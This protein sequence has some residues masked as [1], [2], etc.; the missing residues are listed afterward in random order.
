MKEKNIANNIINSTI[1][2]KNSYFELK[3]KEQGI[4]LVALVITII[5]L[6]ILAT[7]AINFAFGNNGLIQRAE[8]ARDYY[9]NDTSYTDESITNVE[10]YLN[11]IIGGNGGSSSGGKTLVQAFNDGEIKVGDY[12]DYKNPTSGTY[13][14]YATDT[15]MDNAGIDGVTDQVFDVSKNQLN[16]R[17]LGIDEET[18]GLKL[19][20]GSPMKSDNIVN[21]EASPYLYMYGAKSYTNG[22]NILNSIGALYK[23][24]YAEEARSVNMD[25]I[26][27]VTGI[28]TEDDIKRVNLDAY[29]YYANYQYGD[30]YSYENHYTPE[31]WLNGKTPTTVTGTVDGY[32][33]SINSQVEED[34]PYVTMEDTRVYD[35]LFDNV[36]YLT[37]KNYW[38]ASHGITTYSDGYV[39]GAFFGPGMVRA[40]DGIPVAGTIS[41]FFSDGDEFNDFAAVRPVVILKSDVTVEQVHVIADKT[42]EEWSY[43]E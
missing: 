41:M 6:I 10:S 43:I 31:S 22:V 28:T 34:T 4:T 11:E 20:A 39:D 16:W 23:N 37:G 21:G 27:Q 2:T 36:E 29:S 38:L 5:I 24:E 1:K 12:V 7:V 19:I 35:M 18:G 17:V 9:V 26:N 33:Y 25:D 15:G 13:T 42:E 40:G 8:D 3:N 32:Y 30:S 14:A